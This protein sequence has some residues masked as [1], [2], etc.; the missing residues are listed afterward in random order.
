MRGQPRLV[1]GRSLRERFLLS[2]TMT[3]VI[4]LWAYIIPHLP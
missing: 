1:K 4:I 3:T 2:A